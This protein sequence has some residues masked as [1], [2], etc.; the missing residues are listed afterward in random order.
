MS[1]RSFPD[2]TSLLVNTKNKGHW[3]K[4]KHEL[5]L[6]EATSLSTHVH[7]PDVLLTARHQAN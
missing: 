6:I 5:A 1:L 4:L 2:A 7:K 3:A